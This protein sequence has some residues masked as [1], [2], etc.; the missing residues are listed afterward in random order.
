MIDLAEWQT[1]ARRAPQRGTIVVLFA[2]AS[3][4]T[5]Q[6]EQEMQ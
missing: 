4:G 6:P 1:R 5:A 2:I 3:A